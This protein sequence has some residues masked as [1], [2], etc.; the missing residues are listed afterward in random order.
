MAIQIISTL[1]H[2]DESVTLPMAA[3][4]LNALLE[5]INY[6]WDEIHKAC[7]IDA[8]CLTVNTCALHLQ[9]LTF[10]K[11]VFF[12]CIQ[13]RN[14]VDNIHSELL[15][16]LSNG[17]IDLNNSL[18]IAESATRLLNVFR[19]LSEQNKVIKKDI[20][21]CS[22]IIE[23]RE[24]SFSK[25]ALD[26]KIASR[27][28]FTAHL[29][30]AFFA[31]ASGTVV[32]ALL[33]QTIDSAAV[34]GTSVFT[35]SV[36]GAST[37]CSFLQPTTKFEKLRELLTLLRKKIGKLFD[38]VDDLAVRI[39]ELVFELEAYVQKTENCFARVENYNGERM[40]VKFEF[41]VQ[42]TLDLKLSFDEIAA[43][44]K[45]SSQYTRNIIRLN[46]IS[47]LVNN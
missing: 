6:L 16:A 37:L 25:K 20:D 11:Q 26:S 31:A 38:Y 43:Q 33:F 23:E 27:L 3:I 47:N 14:T 18:E 10:M 34:I 17:R 39:T 2:I 7:K 36:V 44:T 15:I 40:R 8:K 28:S 42:T 32:S 24:K 45:E 4:S 30:T 5:E 41:L 19:N 22:N 1:S 35:L 12:E 13:G 9:F 29:G 21:R 46:G